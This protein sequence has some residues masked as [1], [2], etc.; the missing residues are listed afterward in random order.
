[1]PLPDIAGSYAIF[2]LLCLSLTA[3]AVH[4]P[5]V[6]TDADQD[7]TPSLV[8]PV[9]STAEERSWGRS[10]GNV[11]GHIQA[12]PVWEHYRLPGKEA[13]QYAFV[14][15]GDADGRVSVQASSAASASMLRA[16]MAVM[17]EQ[18][19][20]FHFSW[21]V[22]SLI[23]GADLGVR[24][25]D[26]APA[27]VVL[28]FDGDRSR[29]TTREWAMSELAHTITG[30]EL[31][32]ATLMY[33]W[34]NQ[35]PVGTVIVHPRSSRI[36]AI[37]VETGPARVGQ[38]TAY[39]RDV[40]ADFERAFGEPPAKLTGVALMTD[41]DNTRQQAKAWYGPL[42]FEQATASAR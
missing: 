34:C 1:M 27:R 29:F 21:K 13:T 22:A 17:P 42:S 2:G 30:E 8:Q 26:D 31:P 35:R 20:H 6:S 39:N 23:E 33:V 12:V 32:Y 5:A 9:A 28:A 25:S 41:S 24:E 11:S 18:M 38:W 10:L 14:R 4:R 37:V 40:K 19:G 15:T 3:C 7:A 36:R 16:R